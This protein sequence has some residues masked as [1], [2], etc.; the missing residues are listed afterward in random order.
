VLPLRRLA[1]PATARKL[2]PLSVVLALGACVSAPPPGPAVTVLPGK[3]KDLAAFQEDEL[4]CERHAVAHT[5]YT[6]VP[7]SAASVVAGGTA[8]GLPNDGSTHGKAAGDKPGG[9]TVV[10]APIAPGTTAANAPSTVG[11]QPF[12]EAG[13]FQCMASRGDTVQPM[14]AGYTA[15]AYAYDSAYP[16][17][18]VYGYPYGYPYPFYDGG[19]YGGFGW[20][21]WGHGGWHRGG[22]GHGGW[23]HGGWGHGGF[24]HGGFGH[25]GG[26]FG[27]GGGGHR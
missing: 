25:G 13:Y 17:G 4:V 14:P 16:Y 10:G 8:A 21:G 22:W 11:V 23:V 6:A 19:F 12:D 1:V 18:Y 5:G 7:P 20:G 9:D 24:A 26:G 2:A 3:D 27:H 15:S